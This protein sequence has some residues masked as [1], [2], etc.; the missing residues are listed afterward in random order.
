MRENSRKEG[1]KIYSRKEERQKE[2]RM[3]RK[4]EGRNLYK[5]EEAHLELRR[6]FRHHSPTLAMRENWKKKR[7]W[8]GILERRKE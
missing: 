3:R 6:N 5:T 2:G 8:R 1:R 7:R 4:N